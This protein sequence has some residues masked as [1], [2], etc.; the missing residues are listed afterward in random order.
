[1]RRL[2]LMLLVALGCVTTKPR[3]PLDA[4][5][6]WAMQLQGLEAEGAVEALVAAP[7]DLLV[8]EPTRST[9]G[10]ED[11]PTKDVVAR[12]KASGKVCLAYLNVG[13]AESYRTYWRSTWR[14][15]TKDEPGF[16]SFLVTVDPEGWEGN[17]P[18]AYWDLRWRAILWGS[19]RSLLDEAIADG[20]DGVYLDWVLGYEEP[21]VRRLRADAGAEMVKLISELRLY[22]R[23]RK[24]GFLV[25]A[26]NGAGL[27]GLEKVIDG[28]SAEPLRFS[29][30]AGAAWD[31]DE[32][33]DIALPNVADRVAALQQLAVPVFT[34]D[35]A[36]KAENIRL[37]RESSRS[38]GFRPF[39][40]RVALDRLPAE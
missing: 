24:P 10:L 18:V 2:V 11:F 38:L 40:S 29:G 27:P 22:A 3:R 1:M 15:P 23:A 33:G 8:I 9:R 14:A 26:Q 35:Y 16:P 21:A 28:Y 6:T 39:V 5:S 17:Y 25:V 7:V 31:D 19:S 20:F 13:Q 12:I 36:I 4:V 32:A 34:V 37:A 30:K